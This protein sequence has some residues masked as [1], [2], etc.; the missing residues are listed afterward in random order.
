MAL[1]LHQWLALGHVTHRPAIAPAF[2]LH[3]VLPVLVVLAC[4]VSR[5]ARR[6]N[7]LIEAKRKGLQLALEPLDGRGIAGYVPEPKLW[8]RSRRTQPREE[9]NNCR[10]VR[11][12]R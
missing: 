6:G 7:P 1:R 4:S 5:R 12:D 8:A 11:R 3:D 10:R 9:I 2:E